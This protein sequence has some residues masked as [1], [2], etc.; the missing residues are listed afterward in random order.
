MLRAAAAAAAQTQQGIR[1]PSGD[2]SFVNAMY[3][4]ALPPPEAVPEDP[5]AAAEKGA[6]M[7]AAWKA[8]RLAAQ[9]KQQEEDNINGRSPGGSGGG[10]VR[11]KTVVVKTVFAPAASATGDDV[12]AGGVPLR[13]GGAGARMR[14]TSG[15][16]GGLASLR[17]QQGRDASGARTGAGAVPTESNPLHAAMQASAADPPVDA[18]P[19]PP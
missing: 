15:A 7:A 1:G 12:E 13:G 9:L 10:G 6:A 8:A 11:T 5:T 2:V 3:A 14:G 16:G 19:P 17:Q 18:V 4:T